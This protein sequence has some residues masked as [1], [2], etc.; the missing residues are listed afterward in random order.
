MTAYL[1]LSPPALEIQ[2]PSHLLMI[3][4]YTWKKNYIPSIYY[5]RLKLY[6]V[7][8]DELTDSSYRETGEVYTQKSQDASGYIY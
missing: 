4:C 2:N 5:T 8:I 3:I 7:E 1:P 6:S